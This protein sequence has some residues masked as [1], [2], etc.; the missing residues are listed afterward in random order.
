MV[1][2]ADLLSLWYTIN[3]ARTS[4][5][6]LQIP[7]DVQHYDAFLKHIRER[8]RQVNIVCFNKILL[9]ILGC[10]YE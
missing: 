4:I 9:K 7:E 1:E 8:L 3:G 6:L 2:I 5:K 10:L